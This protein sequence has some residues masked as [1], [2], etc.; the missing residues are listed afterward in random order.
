MSFLWTVASIVGMLLFADFV[1]RRIVSGRISHLIENVPLFGVVQVG[2][3][4]AGQALQIPMANGQELAACLYPSKNPAQGVVI[5]C[6]ELNGNRLGAMH[7]C[8]SLCDSGFSVL[9]FDF[10][11][12]G[13]SDF[14]P[15]FKP[16]PWVTNS[17][18]EDLSTVVKYTQTSD[19]FRNLPI[20]L[21]GVSRGGCAALIV[22]AEHPEVLSVIADGAYSTRV[23]INCFM[24]KFCRYI[25]P[26]WLFKRLP[27]WHNRLVVEQALRRSAGRRGREYVHLEDRA[28]DLTQP[29]LLISGSRDSYVT[30][31]ITNQ[32]ATLVGRRVNTWI[33]PKA[34][35]NRS[36]N[37]AA[38][39]YDKRLVQ[40][41]SETL[42]VPPGNASGQHRVA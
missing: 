9:A 24:L 39:E 14:N 21:F 22:A 32:L 17:E 33:V 25:V 8:Q 40:H 28:G 19:E 11:N 4:S 16:T 37:I 7:Y 26:E 2:E 12:Q 36:R 41:F 23:L 15:E 13:D 31:D 42:L 10:R 30:P 6:P 35:H 38:S 3:F 20:G 18:T 34:K 1:Y 27:G 5:F 29:I